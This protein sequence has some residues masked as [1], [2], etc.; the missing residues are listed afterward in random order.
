MKAS[1]PPRRGGAKPPRGAHMTFLRIPA[2]LAALALG[3]LFIA[4]CDSR[5]PTTPGGGGGSGGDPSDLTAPTITFALSAGT[6]NVVDLGAALT[7]K[8]TA[9]DDKGVQ[10]LN[11]TLNNG[12]TVIGADTSSFKPTQ[13][14]TTRTLTVPMAGRKDGDRI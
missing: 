9:T 11:T 3:G 14:T 8:V 2:R 5:L 13:L 6:N 12:A 1:S 7:V 10:T 4:S